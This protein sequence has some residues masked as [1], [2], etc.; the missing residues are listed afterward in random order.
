MLDDRFA[1]LSKSEYVCGLIS[2]SSPAVAAALIEPGVVLLLAGERV[3]ADAVWYTPDEAIAQSLQG[4]SGG[5]GRFIADYDIELDLQSDISPTGDSLLAVRYW[6]WT[7]TREFADKFGFKLKMSNHANAEEFIGRLKDEAIVR[8]GITEAMAKQWYEGVELVHDESGFD[9]S[10]QYALAGHVASGL[11][12]GYPEPDI[13]GFI[14]TPLRRHGELEYVS[15]PSVD[16]FYPNTPQPVYGYN[17]DAEE[18]GSVKK[19]AE[20]W[21]GILSDV[22]SSSMHSELL[23]S[24]DFKR[25]RALMSR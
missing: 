16:K 4:L 19:Q 2:S 8:Y 21:E 25:A 1:G 15:L 12:L 7:N 3:M 5:I 6:S 23:A 10:L 17:P 14:D 13:T 18:A 9:G 24:D 11:L 22:Y 20:R